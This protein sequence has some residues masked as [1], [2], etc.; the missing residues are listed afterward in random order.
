MSELEK[1]LEVA[2]VDIT[3]RRPR[4]DKIWPE[5]GTEQAM[6]FMSLKDI[7][8]RLEELGYAKVVRCRECKHYE[9]CNHWLPILEENLWFCSEGERVVAKDATGEEVPNG[10]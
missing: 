8:D 4:L 2:C 3:L 5:D 7:A 6:R 1:D 9:D 10:R